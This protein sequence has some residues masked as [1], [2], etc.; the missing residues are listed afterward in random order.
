MCFVRDRVLRATEGT[1][2]V[3]CAR[4]TYSYQV[5]FVAPIFI[6][7]RS[8]GVAVAVTDNM[9]V[10]SALLLIQRWF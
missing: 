7:L 8:R 2:P 5:S 9:I 3:A 1:L 10:R 4:A 6:R